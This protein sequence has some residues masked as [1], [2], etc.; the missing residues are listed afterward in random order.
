MQ[1]QSLPSLKALQIFEAAARHRNFSRAAEELHI[2][3][4]AVSKQ[5]RALE[6]HFQ[7][8][9]FQRTRQT[10]TLTPEG[11]RLSRGLGAAFVQLREACRSIAP[12]QVINL[13]LPMSFGDR[14]FMRRLK[15]LEAATGLT[16]SITSCWQQQVDFAHEPF[17]LAIVYN[18]ETPGS[19][20]YEERLVCVAS[21][22]Y[23]NAA[24]NKA[25]EAILRRGPLIY[26]SRVQDD[27]GAFLEA[28]ALTTEALGTRKIQ[29]D[30]MSSA[31]QATLGHAGITV[32]DPL[33]V[34]EELKQGVLQLVTA[35]AV[36]TGY[37]YALLEAPH[38]RGS[39]EAEQFRRWLTQALSESLPPETE[40]SAEEAIQ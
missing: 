15:T 5:I 11:E 10:V 4:G 7:T 26:P 18:P 24:P 34:D 28:Q 29:M 38:M 20:L 30:S 13:K 12:R 16:F 22:D 40:I 6:A 1:S 35:D 17:D 39:S 36:L 31:I 33:L 14:W 21:A 8:S 32:V 3:H 37:H 9:L 23:L 25:P 27:W 2:S 19:P